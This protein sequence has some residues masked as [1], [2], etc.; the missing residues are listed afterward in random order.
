MSNNLRAVTILG[1]A[2]AFC[3]LIL[4]CQTEGRDSIISAVGSYG[5]IAVVLSD[6]EL[7]S[8]LVRFRETMN[9][10]ETFV[11]RQEGTY[12]FHDFTGDNWRNGRNYRN[13]LFVCRWGA[14]GGVESAV[15]KMLSDKTLERLTSGRGGVVTVRDPFFR[16]QLAIVAVARNPNDLVRT[17]N[18]HADALR[19]TLTHDINRRIMADN[20]R[21]GL[22]PGAVENAWRRFG[23]SLE[24][25]DEFQ[26]NQTRP[27]GYPGVE[28]I[29]TDGTMRGVTVS[30]EAVAEPTATLTDHDALATIRA[31]MGEA[32]HDE[33]EIESASFVWT[34]ETVNG[35][36]AVKLAGNWQSRRVEVGGPFW[37]YFMADETNGRVYCVDLLVYAPNKEKMDYFRRLRASLQ[38]FSLEEPSL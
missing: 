25:P 20:R 4:G 27:G 29:R 24:L 3:V 17:L 2:L 8:Y 12:R 18:S 31:G 14:G 21:Q 26:E 23:F 22:L 32:M 28:W 5:D 34:A 7:D 10:T 13:L 36:P 19:D 30:W 37:C 16:N 1:A 9:P 15:K 11:L 6:P 38:T 33:G 35:H